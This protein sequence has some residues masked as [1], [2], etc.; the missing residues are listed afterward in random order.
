MFYLQLFIG[1]KDLVEFCKGN[2]RI[3][4]EKTNPNRENFIKSFFQ[5]AN[6][7]ALCPRFAKVDFAKRQEKQGFSLFL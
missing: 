2:L 4:V 1:Y 5:F 3:L 7:I 6:N